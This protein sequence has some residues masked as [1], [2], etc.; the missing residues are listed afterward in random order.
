MNFKSIITSPHVYPE[1]CVF[2][3]LADIKNK[4][5]TVMGLGLNGGG[6]AAV[7]FF[8]KYGAY[9]VAT[10]MKTAQEL[11]PTVD[12]L[13]NDASLNR[14]RLTYR[15]G[16]HRID[17]FRFA[18]CVI[19]NP[20][21]KYEGNTYLSCAKAIE[22][23]MSIFLAFT[24]APIIAVTGSKGKSSTA[25]AIYFGLSEAGLMAF[26][27]GNITVSPLSFLEKTNETTPVVLELSSWQLADLRGRKL[28]KPRISL[29]TKIV[30]DHQNWYGD[31][32]SYVADKRLIYADQGKNNCSIFDAD[33][34]DEGTPEP[35]AGL[36]WGDFFARESK[37][38]VFRYS[39]QALP[40]GVYGAWQDTD[41]DGKFCGKARLPGNDV[42]VTLLRSVSVPGRHMRANVLNAALVMALSGIG[43]E[44]VSNI[45]S[46]WKGIPHRLQYFHVWNRKRMRFHFYNDSCATVPESAVAAVRSFKVP[47]ILIAGGT[48]KGLPQN[49]LSEA[50]SNDR[51]KRVKA[52][53]LLSGTATDK[54]TELLH[55]SGTAFYGPY[56][57]LG[58]LLGALK[59]NECADD[60]REANEVILF[61]PGAT[62]FGMF[63]NEFDRGLKFM[64]EVK[65][66]FP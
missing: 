55:A 45:L 2:S 58:E 12:S 35:E 21:V 56:D 18:D 23:D 48:D 49:P 38:T 39:M 53:Y 17:D 29:I 31:M 15:L 66:V 47:V 25:S 5:I 33:A 36:S 52:L 51:R 65:R 37:A 28:L 7:R 9:V 14:T 3:S 20:G 13:N 11:K 61:S 1:G 64:E 60:E 42:P 19:K 57:S 46:R 41:A 54:L 22:T 50:L 40:Q 62:S 63:T 34:D 16:E 32:A 59:A 26:L 24:K 43:A 30:P 44:T 8:L 10:D 6:E 27:G 4:H